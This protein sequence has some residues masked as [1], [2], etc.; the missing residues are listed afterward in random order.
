MLDRAEQAEG[1]RPGE[2]PVAI[3]GTLEDSGLSVPHKGFEHLAA[4]DAAQG[5]Y[6]VA[7]EEDVTWYMWDVL[8]YPCNLVSSFELSELEEREEVKSM[9]AYPA[10]GCCQWVEDTLVIKLSQGGDGR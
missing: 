4:L 2:T 6:A 9:P 8:G 1:Y 5:N 3:V 10:E 7:S